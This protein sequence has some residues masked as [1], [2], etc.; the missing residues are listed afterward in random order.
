MLTVSAQSDNL[1][2]G[3]GDKDSVPNKLGKKIKIYYG[4]E[5]L[6]H[7][8][9]NHSVEIKINKKIRCLDINSLLNHLESIGISLN[10]IENKQ[11]IINEIKQIG[12]NAFIKKHRSQLLVSSKIFG[13]NFSNFWKIYYS[14]KLDYYLAKGDTLAAMK[15]VRKGALVNRTFYVDLRNNFWYSR[16][17]LDKELMGIKIYRSGYVGYSPLAFSLKKKHYELANLIFKAKGENLLPSDKVKTY[18]MKL[19]D[20][21]YDSRT[22]K[23]R[24]EKTEK[25][26]LKNGKLILREL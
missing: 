7:Q 4:C 22:Y 6:F 24:V 5:K 12:Y 20:I 19:K 23:F 1:Y 10:S 26:I 18:D 14:R 11:E 15:Q 13:S 16:N 3:Y 17:K 8:L 25:V 21:S 9:F 2:I